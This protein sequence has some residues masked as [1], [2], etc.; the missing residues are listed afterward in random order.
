MRFQFE[1]TE[2]EAKEFNR[3]FEDVK[4]KGASSK[5]DVINYALA[6]LNWAIK[7]RQ[8]GRIIASIDEDN[9]RYKE[10][11]LPIFPPIKEKAA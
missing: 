11:V 2:E 4:K 8:A 9:E 1:M 6:L 3:L 10:V 5:R 7:E